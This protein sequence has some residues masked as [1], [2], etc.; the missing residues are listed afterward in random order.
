M[1]DTYTSNIPVARGITVSGRVQGVGFRPFV[2]RLALRF[3]LVGS[4]SNR[5]GQVE[6][7]AEGAANQIDRFVAALW[8]EA[9]P[10]SRPSSVTQAEVAATGLAGFAILDSAADGDSCMAGGIHIPPDLFCCDDCLAE[11]S[12]PDARR[13]GYPFTNCTQCGPR[14]TII[15]AMP[16]DRAST[17][18]AGFA[19]CPDCQ[20][21]YA[22]PGDRRFHAQPLACPRCGP[23]LSFEQEKS[24]WPALPSDPLEAAATLLMQGKIVA[25]RGVGGYHLMADASNHAAVLR[26]RARKN[27]PRKPLAVMFPQTGPDGL[28]ALAPHVCPTSDEAAACLGPDRPIVTMTRRPGCSLSAALAPGLAT[29]GVFLPYS[30]LHHLLLARVNRPLVATS[31]N[32]SGEPVL[33][34]PEEAADRLHGLAD[35]IL[36]HDRPILRPVEDSVQQVMAH[37]RSPIRIGRGQA[38][39]ELDLPADIG[40]P[41]IAVGGHM[42]GAVALAWGRRAVLSAHIG[43]LDSPRSRAVFEQTIADLQNLYQVKATHVLCDTNPSYASTQWARQQ[44]LPVGTIQHHRAHASALAGEHDDVARWLVFAWDGTGLGDDRTIWGAET[45]VGGPGDW[46]RRASL[47]PLHLL[48]PDKAARQPWRTAAAMMWAVGMTYR[49]PITDAT[50]A[51]EAWS[52]RTATMPASSMGRLL[53][54]AAGLVLGLNRASYEG[55]GPALLEALAGRTVNR[56]SRPKAMP[57]PQVVD[58]HGILRADWAPLLPVLTDRS[59]ST[60][61]RAAF[62]HETLAR[63]ILDQAVL[64]RRSG[65]AFDAIGLTGGVF[66]NRILSDRAGEVLRAEGFDVRRHGVVPPNDGGLAFGQVIEHLN[67]PNMGSAQ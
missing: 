40:P 1:P 19:L 16:Y 23:S 53:D 3:G 63:L 32:P 26:L 50:L 2:Y 36:H 9:P 55:E 5:A 17:G 18:M 58:D 30:P 65:L 4:V 31:A 24:L 15:A 57:L 61:D 29:L 20:R 41:V 48:G 11:I 67:M 33:T 66:Q 46:Q 62:L 54:G 6:I 12:D 37:G 64:L 25:V 8:E 7:L 27:R 51:H 42:K 39:L 28:Q 44:D 60:A 34:E 43:D 38:P 35:A 21:E 59:R 56:G 45:F 49:P 47:R 22:D 14:Y 10:L 13:L 52:R